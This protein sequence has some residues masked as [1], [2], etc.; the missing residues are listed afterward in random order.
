MVNDSTTATESIPSGTLSLQRHQRAA[1]FRSRTITT[2]IGALVRMRLVK[3]DSGTAH[4]I[5][6]EDRAAS[7]ALR[8]DSDG[9]SV[10]GTSLE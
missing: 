9:V 10:I 3:V 2:Q 1:A 7:R 5:E 8:A 4:K 6:F